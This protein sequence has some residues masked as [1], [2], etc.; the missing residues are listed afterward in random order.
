MRLRG[1]LVH[2]ARQGASVVFTIRVNEAQS[3]REIF[4]QRFVEA[5]GEAFELDEP[6]QCAEDFVEVTVRSEISRW[7]RAPNFA[8]GRIV[9]LSC[10]PAA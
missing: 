10:A 7:Q 2:G 3:G 4:N 1:A 5:P 8:W 6:M 9:G